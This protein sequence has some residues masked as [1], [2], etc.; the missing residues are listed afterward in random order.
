[1]NKVDII[2]IEIGGPGGRTEYSR[3]AKMIKKLLMDAGVQDI[4]IVDTNGRYVHDRS[5]DEIKLFL[6]AKPCKV[7]INVV[8]HPWGG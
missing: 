7:V 2:N 3:D 5:D 1:M 8:H 6:G 4:E